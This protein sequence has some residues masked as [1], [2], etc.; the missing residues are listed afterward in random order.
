MHRRTGSSYKHSITTE[1]STATDSLYIKEG[2]RLWI[3]FVETGLGGDVIKK[4]K[5]ANG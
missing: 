5:V 4:K 3:T 1:N 2:F